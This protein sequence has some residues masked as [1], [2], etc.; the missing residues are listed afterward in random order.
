[1]E[2]NKENGSLIQV[3]RWGARLTGMGMVILFLVFFI[4]ESWDHPAPLPFVSLG[5]EESLEMVA[6]L[7]MAVGAL[8]GWR[9]ERLGGWLSLLGGLGF[10]VIESL[11]SGHLDLVWFPLVFA[12]V[13]AAFLVCDRVDRI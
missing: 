12:A 9:R 4:G 3:L 13:G 1:M 5:I 7:V 10:V 2:N 6:T 8:V 11:G